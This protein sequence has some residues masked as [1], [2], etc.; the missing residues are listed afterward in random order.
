MQRRHSHA[1]LLDYLTNFQPEQIA[2]SPIDRN[3]VLWQA[4][5]LELSEFPY[6]GSVEPGSDTDSYWKRTEVVQ[7]WPFASSYQV[8]PAAWAPDVMP[9][10]SPV[11][12]SSNLFNVAPG[13][14]F[15]GRRQSEVNFPSAK[16]HMFE[17]FDRITNRAGI[18]YSYEQA[19]C[20]ILFF[21]GS[22]RQLMTSASNPGWKPNEPDIYFR[23]A[24]APLDKYPRALESPPRH[25]LV[26]Y[27]WT[28]MGLRGI[29]FGGKDIGVPDALDGVTP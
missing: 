17:E 7:R 20:N 24:Y 8:V 19:N 21:D 2:A 29:D 26:H 11:A 5:P 6:S 14:V 10:V 23:Q 13:T 27:R 9:T 15:G 22:V 28:R 25:N 4:D 12:S 1:V 3:Q 18:F 16:V